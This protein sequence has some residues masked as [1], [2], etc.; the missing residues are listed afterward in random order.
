MNNKYFSEIVLLTRSYY[1]E[2]LECWLKWHLDILGFDHIV[3][4]DNESLIDIPKI[5]EKY[6]DRVSYHF[7]Q[8]W[9]D[10]HTLYTN[11]A[12]Q[13]ESQWLITLDDDEYL[14]VSPKY[15]GSVH[16]LLD[17][18]YSQYHKNKYYPLWVNM[19]SKEPMEKRE[20]LFLL[21]HTYYS[22]EAFYSLRCVWGKDNRLGKCFIN[23]DFT[24][25]Y[26]KG[27]S[28]HIPKCIDG[29][30]DTL[31]ING[32]KTKIDLVDNTA[33]NKDCFIAHYQMK[34]KEDWIRKC[35]GLSVKSGKCYINISK[36]F[37]DRVFKYKNNFKLCTL[38]VDLF[39]NI[40]I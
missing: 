7:I 20:G 38:L 21:S 14:Y 16:F 25:Q 19:I 39:S 13:S 6:K 37:Y 32:S 26:G 30:D 11:Y 2:E 34:S 12:K 22:Y 5:I 27:L 28:G 8:G 23:T 40:S 36:T 29:D 35:N 24:Y 18:L 4:F 17:S 33:I 10:Q 9:P 15:K 1:I 31:L 3:L